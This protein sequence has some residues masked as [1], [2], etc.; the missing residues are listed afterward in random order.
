MSIS[1]ALKRKVRKSIKTLEAEIESLKAQLKN[2][3]KKP[4]K[5]TEDRKRE[6][7]KDPDHCPYCG[8]TYISG[9]MVDLFTQGAAQPVK[10]TE[11][12]RTWH[13]IYE[14]VGVEEAK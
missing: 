6:Y 3:K 5:L 14:L 12:G 9:S 10:C 4:A 11:C 1:A 7:L 2:G 8:S 13:D